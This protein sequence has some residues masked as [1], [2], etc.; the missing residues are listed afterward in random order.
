[1]SENNV[2]LFVTR[3]ESE[4]TVELMKKLRKFPKSESEIKSVYGENSLNGLERSTTQDVV[5][6][7]AEVRDFAGTWSFV[8]RRNY[9][10]V[11]HIPEFADALKVW[12]DSVI[13][14]IKTLKG[15]DGY[16]RIDNLTEAEISRFDTELF[17]AEN[18]EQFISVSGTVEY[19]KASIASAK[20]MVGSLNTQLA[21]HKEIMSGRIKPMLERLLGG[22]GGTAVSRFDELEKAKA[23]YLEETGPFLRK[24][25]GELYD[26]YIAGLPDA[27]HFGVVE[28]VNRAMVSVKS[29]R[30]AGL[31]N[32]LIELNLISPELEV[33]WRNCYDLYSGVNLLS[34]FSER[35]ISNA[36]KLEAVWIDALAFIESSETKISSI[37]DNRSLRVFVVDVKG[38][39]ND[40]QKIKEDANVAKDYLPK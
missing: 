11:L 4:E 31:N 13:A 20:Y 24:R 25:S 34:S 30:V 40:W 3:S 18:R 22:Q 37:T 15:A 5:K 33:V 27:A 9:D 35:M 17:T 38:V 39:V 26:E 19:L 16:Q 6:L 36:K 12:G 23:R 14:V 10:L 1:M 7:F 29:D 21:M 8:D 28:R 2:A 32:Y